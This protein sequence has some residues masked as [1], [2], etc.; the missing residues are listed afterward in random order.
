MIRS[1]VGMR[2][3]LSDLNTQL[4]TGLKA[5]TYGGLGD[6]RSL[7][8]N[9][10]TKMARLNN[11]SGTINT[12]GVRLQT[13]Y[14][15]LDRMN[16]LTS[17]VSTQ[18]DSNTFDVLSD[19]QTSQQKVAGN[20]MQEMV[21]LLNTDMAGS[22]L[23]GGRKTDGQPV[24]TVD[25]IMNGSGARAGF[26]QI[27]SER[28]QADQG[29]GLGRLTLSSTTGT[30]NLAED[31]THPFGFKIAQITSTLS[32]ATVT[33]PTGTPPAA[34]VSLTG[35]PVAGETLT[36]TLTLPDGTTKDVK[37][38]AGDANNTTTGVFGIGATPDD[39]AANIETVLRAKLQDAGKQELVAASAYAAAKNFFNTFNGKPAQR[40]DG[41]PFATATAL[42]DGTDA[43]TL[44][45]Y[46]GENTQNST[47]GWSP[48]QDV[49][50]NVDT[51]ISVQYGVRANEDSFADAI[52]RYA[53][54]SAL[55]LS[56][57]DKDAL[58]IHQAAMQRAKAA[59]AAPTNDIETVELEIVH[60][61][62]SVEV[63]KD[64]HKTLTSS[65]GTTLDSIKNSDD[66]EV[67]VQIQTLKTRMEASYS[68]TSTL[69]NLSLTKY[70]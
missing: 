14:T 9:L 40:V 32:N 30:V 33:G 1:L 70:L 65:Y 66:T 35:Q 49:A 11:Y 27:V 36:V 20:A 60:A 13:M 12:L 58:G 24:A 37:I 62:Q 48:R 34:S 8:L 47:V 38:V 46:K 25:E 43:D 67:A 56:A 69:F 44:A 31:G 29:D 59:L 42:K 6:Q 18:M 17:E 68:A 22:Y 23:Y 41:P 4:A 55:N 26:R 64:R 50:T 28:L 45:W 61:Q 52:G 10:S 51:S 2:S 3:T 57:N 16:K 21:D 63:A 7:A 53:A 19:G 15:T 5:Q 39:T 54:V